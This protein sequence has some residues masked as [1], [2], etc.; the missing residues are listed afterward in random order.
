M[1]VSF[2][3][4]WWLAPLAI[5]A[6]AFLWA[7]WMHKDDQLAGDYDRIGQAMAELMTAAAATIV[8][9]MAWLIWA[10]AT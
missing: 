7:R 6:A 10:L 1:S 2:V 3:L 8:S 5:T 9:L 4:G